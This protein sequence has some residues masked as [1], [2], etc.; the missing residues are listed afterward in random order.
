M[1]KTRPQLRL[2]VIGIPSER[3]KRKVARLGLQEVI[4]FTGRVE[5]EEIARAYARST[6]AI[7]P[8]LYEGFG[9][10]AGEAMACE[11]PVVASNTGG[12]P[13][14]IKH[15][16]S[17]WLA[18]VGDIDSMIEGAIHI[19]ENKSRH[20]LFSKNARKRAAEEFNADKVVGA[21]EALYEEILE[22]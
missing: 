22:N 8:S 3:T 18:D 9:F 11:V 5:A 6:I 12:L 21:Y 20:E 17:G 4:H 15:G 2:T 7:V 14:V 13:E 1:Y 19:L 10:P 16:H